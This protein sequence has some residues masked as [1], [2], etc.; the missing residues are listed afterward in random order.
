PGQRWEMQARELRLVGGADAA[1]PL[2]K[3]GHT[4]EFLRTIAHL[5]PRTNLFGNVFRVRSRMSYA[6]HRFFQERG[7][8]HVHTPVITSNDCEGA[9]EM[10]RVTT[11]KPGGNA[12]AEDDFFG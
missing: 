12:R 11:L 2:Q 4:P 3:K 8:I 1:Y 7:F 6:V 5:R 9:G 10:F